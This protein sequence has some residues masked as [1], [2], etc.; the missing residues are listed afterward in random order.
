M[1]GETLVL[2]ELSARIRSLEL[3]LKARD[4][5]FWDEYQGYLVASRKEVKNP[6][7]VLKLL[8]DDKL[9]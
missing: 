8:K 7:D 5:S 6:F 9:N 2:V 4:P 1:E 3:Y